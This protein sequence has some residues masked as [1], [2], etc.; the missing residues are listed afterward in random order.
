MKGIK[1]YN[2]PVED[3]IAVCIAYFNIGEYTKPL[4]HLLYTT[5]I[6][7][8]SGIPYYIIELTYKNQTP[9]L[10][11]SE[12]IFHVHSDSCMFHKENLLNLLAGKLPDKYTKIVC[13]DGDVIFDNIN[14]INEVSSKL[15][16]HDVVVPYHNA[17]NMSPFYN[18]IIGQGVTLLDVKSDLPLGVYCAGYGIAFNRSFF[19]KIG[20]Y[21]YAILGGG[22]RM[23]LHQFARRPIMVNP[24]NSAKKEE[25]LE[26]IKSS[27]LK[28]THLQSSVYHLYHG[29]ND[30]RK[31]LER[32]F[33]LDQLQLDKEVIKNED[34]VLEFTNPNQYSPLVENYFMT[35]N[36][37]L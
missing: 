15:E 6:L 2:K 35:R 18:E 33:F 28:F 22:D 12:N 17:F 21:E 7:E 20:L 32:H 29:S 24:F 8:A 27:S 25:Y 36:E 1:K 31:Y 5:N 19:K 30:N 26:K 10:P 3:T 9:S 14:W 13:L 16:S 34:G 11:Y 37:D 4:M 23:T